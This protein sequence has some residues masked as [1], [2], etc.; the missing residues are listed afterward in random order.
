MGF[1]ALLYDAF[2]HFS[3]K[4]A[5]DLHFS[6][7]KTFF[8][9]YRILFFPECH[10]FIFCVCFFACL[11]NDFDGCPIGGLFFLNYVNIFLIVSI[12]QVSGHS[13]IYLIVD[14]FHTVL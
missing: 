14:L 9:L 12:I 7:F 3:V 5:S 2:I 11:F 4:L 13:S 10:V 6:F 8:S 1:G